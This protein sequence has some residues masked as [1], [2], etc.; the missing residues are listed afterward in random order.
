MRRTAA[1]RELEMDIHR[2]DGRT[3]GR[4]DG[5]SR[6]KRSLRILLRYT[7]SLAHWLGARSLESLHSYLHTEGDEE[8][9][10]AAITTT[11]RPA[12][13]RRRLRE[14]SLHLDRGMAANGA[15]HGWK[16][17]NLEAFLPLTPA[18]SPRDLAYPGPPASSTHAQVV[19]T[20]KRLGRRWRRRDGQS[21]CRS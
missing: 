18:S 2:E 6:N 17:Q 5:R 3:D 11:D 7:H 16:S 8:G 10:R 14:H 4:T 19:N 13:G 1:R 15:T 9:Y 12:A 20:C 21:P